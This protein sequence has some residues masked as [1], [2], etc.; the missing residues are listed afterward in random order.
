MRYKG[1]FFI[2]EL[3]KEMKIAKYVVY[4]AQVLFH[5][6]Y[7]LQSFH[8][9]NRYVISVAALFLAAKVEESMSKHKHLQVTTDHYFKLRQRYNYKPSQEVNKRNNIF[10]ISF[11]FIYFQKN[12]FRRIK[13]TFRLM[14]FWL[15]GFFCKRYV[16]IF[17]LSILLKHILIK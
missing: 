3:G 15:K 8:T 4:T 7:T 13:K 16:S 6:F 17:R 12:T 14:L 11:T 10:G 2:D 1:A 5:R 9:H